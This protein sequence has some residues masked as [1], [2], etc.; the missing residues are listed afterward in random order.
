MASLSIDE[1]KE[2]VRI[3][4]AHIQKGSF[5][6]AER[7]LSDVLINIKKDYMNLESSVPTNHDIALLIQEMRNGFSKMDKRF[8]AVDKRFEAMDKRFDDLIHQMDKRFESM[9]KR[10]DDLIHLM[11]KRFEQ[12]DKRFSFMQWAFALFL[13]LIGIMQG[14]LL[15]I[16]STKNF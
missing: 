16:L 3:V 14:L 6:D 2:K 10:F 9:D 7:N 8:E 1:T 12:V 11:D 5:E 13:S 4:I 15:G